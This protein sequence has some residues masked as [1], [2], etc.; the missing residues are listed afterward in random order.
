VIARVVIVV[1]AV[2]VLVW[3]GVMERDLRLEVR[4]G[5]ALRSKGDPAVL[6][7][8]ET[9][10]RRAN[11]LNPGTSADVSRALVRQARGHTHQSVALM[12]DVVRREPENVTAWRVLA[13]LSPADARRSLAVQRRL[14]PLIAPRR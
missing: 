11:L 13:V 9:D 1:T 2:L 7:R 5:A 14:D 6:A 10:L 4:G 8:A 12:H 3:L